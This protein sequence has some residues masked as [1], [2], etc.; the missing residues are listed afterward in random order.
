MLQALVID[1]YCSDT[2]FAPDGK[3]VAVTTGVGRLDTG[4]K[5]LF[6]LDATTGRD[7]WLG[8]ASGMLCVT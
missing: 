6:V 7:V 1:V 5:R 3:R 2:T 8:R 4:G